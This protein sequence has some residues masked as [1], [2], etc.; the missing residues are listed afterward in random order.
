[1]QLQPGRVYQRK[2]LHAYFGG[3][4]QGGI[5]KK[6]GIFSSLLSFPRVLTVAQWE[7][8]SGKVL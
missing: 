8:F 7:V 3:Q 6:D 4:R 1:M 2:D 5:V